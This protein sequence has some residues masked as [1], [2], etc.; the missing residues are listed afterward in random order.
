MNKEQ[1]M[2]LNNEIRLTTDMIEIG[3]EYINDVEISA[4]G[5]VKK[6][7]KEKHLIISLFNEN[8]YDP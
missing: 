2:K 4:T 3:H 1:L 6:S 5:L 7:V 8:Q